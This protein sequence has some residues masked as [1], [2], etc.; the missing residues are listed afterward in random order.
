MSLFLRE[1]F[2]PQRGNLQ[3]WLSYEHAPDWRDQAACKGKTDLFF[4]EAR[5]TNQHKQ[6]KDCRAIC[7]ECPVIDDCR[8]WA[9]AE[10]IDYGF[11]GGM[12]VN[13][14][15]EIRRKRRVA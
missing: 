10:H 6:I 3:S 11:V 13:E 1:V 14:R 15:R 2:D 9:L 4:I 8:R 5:C 12:T 7:E